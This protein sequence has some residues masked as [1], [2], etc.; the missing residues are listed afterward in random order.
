M[1]MYAVNDTLIVSWFEPYQ[2]KMYVASET[3]KNSTPKYPE[4]K[5]ELEELAASIDE[6]D[7]PVLMHV[8]LKE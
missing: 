6:N 3:F 4:K 2:L 8:K 1:P 7:N 5:K